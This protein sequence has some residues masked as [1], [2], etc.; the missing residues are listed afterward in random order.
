[1]EPVG[2]LSALAEISVGLAGFAA[3]V[4]V[5][6]SRGQVDAES[7]ALVRVLISTAVGCALLSIFGIAV[8]GLGV[9]P[10]RAWRISSAVTVVSFVAMTVLNYRLFLRDVTPRLYS[11]SALI[12]HALSLI[13]LCLHLSNVLQFPAP[14]S[15][16]VFYA[17]QAALLSLAGYSFIYMI[18]ELLSRPTA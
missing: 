9:D 5:F 8:L 11:T 2:A 6:G 10:P 3:I 12:G 18:Y 15:F 16:G 1:M 13:C 4:L 14:A 17:G 7:A